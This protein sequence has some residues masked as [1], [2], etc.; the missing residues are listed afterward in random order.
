V[1]NVN[2]LQ[3]SMDGDSRGH[4]IAASMRGPAEALQLKPIATVVSSDTVGGAAEAGRGESFGGAL[5]RI[6]KGL[7]MEQQSQVLMLQGKAYA[8][9]GDFDPAFECFNRAISLHIDVA[10]FVIRAQAYEK[11]FM[12]TEAYFDYSFAIRLDPGAG[13]LFGHRSQCLARLGKLDLALEDLARCCALDSALPNL[14]NKASLLLECRLYKEALAGNSPT[15]IRRLIRSAHINCNLFICVDF[16]SIL[17][18]DESRRELSAEQRLRCKYF[19]SLCHIELG[20]C[21]SAFPDLLA[22]LK[23]CPGSSAAR[24]LLSKAYRLVG[25]PLN[26]EAQISLVIEGGGPDV[27]PE[28]FVERAHSRIALNNIIAAIEGYKVYINIY[29]CIGFL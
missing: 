14:L 27:S 17:I 3:I 10:N 2:V 18:G 5:L 28:H 12:W 1:E 7:T 25:D 22:V 15:C 26:A 24:A 13:V 4:E 9:K 21:A 8:E 11:C 6:V 16:Q 19:S 23:E 20:D 29:Y